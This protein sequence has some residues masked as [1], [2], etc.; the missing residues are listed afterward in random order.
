MKKWLKI[1]GIFLGL[2]LFSTL[3]ISTI[4]GGICVD[5]DQEAERVVFHCSAALRTSLIKS[6]GDAPEFA[7]IYF[8]RAI[9]NAKL[10]NSIEAENDFKQVLTL[11]GV[12]SGDT[13]SA[14]VRDKTRLAKLFYIMQKK[15]PSSEQYAAWI[16][17]VSD[18]GVVMG[19]DQ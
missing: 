6:S 13:L 1:I 11:M 18:F 9:A 12:S 17:A 16:S 5:E 4:F 14:I 3:F 8:H 19:A 7:E 15:S 2:G 10:G